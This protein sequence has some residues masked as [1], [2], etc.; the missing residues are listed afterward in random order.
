MLGASLVC[1]RWRHLIAAIA[2]QMCSVPGGAGEPLSSV[3]DLR[4]GV[5]LYE[6]Y[7]ENYLAALSELKVA[8]ARGGIEGHKDNPKLIEGGLSLAFGMERRA[9]QLFS[10]LL[11]EDRPLAVR[12]AAWFYLSKL[13]YLR[14]DW[15]GAL[16]SLGRVQGEVDPAMA[17]ELAALNVNV[18]IRQDDLAQA[19]QLMASTPELG[20]WL[21]YLYYNLG[22][23]HSRN[24]EY[25]KAVDYF[26]RLT[27]LEVPHA[28]PRQREQLALYDKALTAAGYS[29]LLQGRSLD[30]INYFRQVRRE[31]DFSYRALLGYGWAAAGREDFERALQS[32]QT[33]SQ[34]SIALPSVQEATLA[35]PYAY[36]KLDAPGQALTAFEQAALTFEQEL[37]HI[38]AALA[39][40]D[41]QSLRALLAGAD[42]N[43][44]HRNWFLLS[45]DADVAE[46]PEGI[47]TKN[48]LTGL[49]VRNRYQG[50]V[51]ELQDLLQL[52]HILADWDSKLETYSEMLEERAKGRA[53]KEKAIA[54]H[55]LQQRQ[56]DLTARR[57][58]LVD[59]IERIKRERDYLALADGETAE[60]Y[61]MVQRMEADVARLQ[62]ADESVDEYRV[63]LQRYRGILMWRAAESFSGQLWQSRKRL[64]GLDQALD[65]LATN[66][67]RLQTAVVTAPD[68]VPYQRRIATLNQRLVQQRAAVDQT[69]AL[70]ERNLRRQLAERLQQQR[71]RL[72]HYLAQAR[73][74][75]ARLYDVALTN[76]A[77]G[78]EAGATQ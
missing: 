11:T 6:Y 53:A 33:L 26:V 77:S 47:L 18:A 51:Q 27:A 32:W 60:L 15:E 21:P 57:Q 16:D 5:T 73:L 10:E 69:I 59:S 3:A 28:Q 67:Q 64:A 68:V 50:A 76:R 1:G 39:S 23:A 4:Y 66:Q 65:D 49:F 8:E 20:S 42:K 40:L 12:N 25:D 41:Q 45:A 22:A 74:S 43:V 30:A 54:E 56:Q 34:R 13:R 9:G 37:E 62:T 35:V 78:D 71:Q 58:S 70:A 44:R 61:A 52:Q 63:P 7:Q 24:S 14:G 36:E 31:S 75:I 38:D 48:Y 19:G 46:T 17:T 29:R 55:R 72:R 2:C